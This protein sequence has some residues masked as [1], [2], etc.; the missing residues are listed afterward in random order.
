M[1]NLLSLDFK[2]FV[3]KSDIFIR[4][5]IVNQYYT[6][7]YCSTLPN[8]GHVPGKKS[9]TDFL[10]TCHWIINTF[11]N[12]AIWIH[13]LVGSADTYL[14]WFVCSQKSQKIQFSF[15]ICLLDNGQTCWQKLIAR[16]YEQ[17]KIH[18][19]NYSENSL[20]PLHGSRKEKSVAPGSYLNFDANCF[21]KWLP[22]LGGLFGSCANPNHVSVEKW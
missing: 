11:G 21:I 3:R 8:S 22:V 4:W 18:Q 7:V 9:R 17:L 16:K 15:D 6:V 12:E 19:Q 10:Y 14:N 2:V 5:Q 20:T 13:N 1:I